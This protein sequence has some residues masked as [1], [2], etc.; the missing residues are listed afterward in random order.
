MKGWNIVITWWFCVIL[1]EA[2]QAFFWYTWTSLNR[3]VVIKQ[4]TISEV[5]NQFIT[6]VNAALRFERSLKY[7][8][9]KFK[10][11]YMYMYLSLSTF[12]YVHRLQ[13]CLLGN[14]C[15]S[16]YQAHTFYCFP[17]CRQLV[18]H[19]TIFIVAVL[20]AREF[21]DIDLM[22]PPPAP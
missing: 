16:N 11:L 14:P 1:V 10:N 13:W 6:I 12:L 2:N 4:C 18:K 15:E 3:A 22:A 8:Q 7:I 21:S 20:A 9:L 5:L 17:C 19:T